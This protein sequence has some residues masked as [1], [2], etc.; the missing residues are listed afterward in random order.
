MN[1]T[2]RN[3]RGM[4][5]VFIALAVLLAASAVLSRVLSGSLAT[6]T[7]LAIAGAKMILIG[8]FFMRLRERP[9]LIRLAA[10][11]GLAWLALLLVLVLADY[12]T[13]SWHGRPAEMSDAIAAPPSG[14]SP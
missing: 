12:R 13:R 4:V 5:G 14:N 10:L 3:L 9:G 7:G 1:E 6:A 11:T 8:V 2:A